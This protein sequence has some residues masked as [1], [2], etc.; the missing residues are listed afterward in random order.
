MSAKAASIKLLELA[1]KVKECLLRFWEQLLELTRQHLALVRS[2]VHRLKQGFF[3]RLLGAKIYKILQIELPVSLECLVD[4]LSHFNDLFDVFVHEELFLGVNLVE[5]V[6][7]LDFEFAK[8]VVRVFW[9]GR[10]VVNVVRLSTLG[11][12]LDFT[13][14]TGEFIKD[15]AVG[16]D[17]N[18]RLMLQNGRVIG[19]LRQTDFI[20]F[21]RLLCDFGCLWQHLRLVNSLATAITWTVIG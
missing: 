6:L 7:H 20:L 14:W 1:R 15:S 3:V 8:A 16:T 9:A 12:C 17:V 10:L 5:D 13:G 19:I 2:P 18:L 11:V 4:P 21:S